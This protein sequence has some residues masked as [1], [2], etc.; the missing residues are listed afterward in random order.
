[1][2]IKIE[3]SSTG[4]REHI[5]RTIA[6][7]GTRVYMRETGKYLEVEALAGALREKSALGLLKQWVR[8]VW[9]GLHRFEQ[10]KHLKKESGRKVTWESELS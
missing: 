3:I 5:I 2:T 8:L 1:M 10:P 9:P 7:M 4:L 6:E